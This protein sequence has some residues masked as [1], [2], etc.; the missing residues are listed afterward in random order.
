MDI[1]MQLTIV[2]VKA[3]QNL[4]SFHRREVTGSDKQQIQRRLSKIKYVGRG[5]SPE[6]HAGR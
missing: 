1:L 4:Y 3:K 2:I 6:N 5:R